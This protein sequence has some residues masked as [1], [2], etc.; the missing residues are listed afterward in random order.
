MLSVAELNRRPSRPP[1]YE[2]ENRALLALAESMA[3]SP[4][5]VLQK[6]ADAALV[7]CRAHSAG[8]SL[9][10]D[11]DQ[12]RNFHW[13]A[14]VGQWAPHVGG[15][16]PRDFGPCGTVLDNNTAMLCCRPERDFP[17]LG[18]VSPLLDEGLLIPFH[19]DGEAVGTIW[20][21]SHDESR[22]FDAEDLRVMTN[23]ATFAS[24]AYQTLLSRDAAR[25]SEA[26]I[27]I[28]AHEAEHRANNVLA[29]VQATVQLSS[30][31]T[32]DGLKHAI[33]G[34]IQALAGVHRLF[35]ESRWMGAELQ[36][37]VTQELLPYRQDGQARARIEGPRLVLEPNTAQ[38]IAVIL[39]ELATNAVK[40]G[41]LS[42]TTGRVEVEWSRSPD[43][44][45]VLRW[46]EIDG[47][48]VKS[49]TRQGFGT[50]VMQGMVRGLRGDIHFDW[51]EEGLSA[52][53]S[54]PM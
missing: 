15:G 37:L 50:V 40:Y 8:F 6:F 9:L 47:P 19:V 10:E 46:I 48:P 39:H 35:V 13:R 54:I 2:A 24:S 27:A 4:E 43:G 49:P 44:Q 36:K 42:R 25:R 45:L 31:D 14:I 38:T 20:V 52:E 29:T 28:L 53:I 12:K 33:Q 34:R 16:T 3:L 5:G 32:P 7:L 11:A 26:Q 17:Y 41:A 23:L 22:R 30:S 51:R 1:D 21:I 18:E